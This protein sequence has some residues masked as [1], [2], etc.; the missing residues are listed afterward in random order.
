MSPPI[1][2]IDLGT[3]YSLVS[4][5]QAGV[6]LV[7]PNV[8]GE[9]LTPSAVS[10]REDG[11]LLVGA[12]AR[13]RATTHPERTALAFKRDMGTQRQLQL[14]ERTFSPVELSAL[15][16]E[17]LKRDAEVALG[18]AIT[19]AVVT[20]PAYFGDLQRQATRDAGALAGLVVERIV[21]EPTAAA[22]AYGLHERSRDQRVVV[23]DLGGGTF[24]VTVL[25]L[26]EGVM[27]V[28]ASA[29]DVRLGGEDFTQVLAERLAERF[30]RERGLRPAEDLRAWARLLEASEAAKQRLSQADQVAVLLPQLSCGKRAPIDFEEV[31]TRDEAEAC[32]A[33]L[34]ARLRAPVLRALRDAGIGAGQV[35]EVLLVGGATRMPVVQRLVTEL[36]G[37]LPLR[38]LPPDEA[39][40]MGA[41]VQAALKD[42]DRSVKD[43]VVTDVAP[44]TLGINTASHS[45][46]RVVTGLF[47]PI[48]ERGTVIPASRMARVQTVADYQSEIRV[49]VYQGEHSLC[50]DNQKLGE[51]RLSSLPPRPAGDESVD[52]RLTY[53][54]NGIVEVEMTVVSTGTVESFVIEQRPGQLSA[55]EL[56]KARAAMAGLKLHPR[57]ALPNTTALA[58]ADARFMELT[59]PER[60]QLGHAIAMMR[61]ALETQEV[62]EVL[63]WRERLNALISLSRR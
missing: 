26:V 17:S 14:G 29:G 24:D 21:N 41:A 13:A 23:L 40:A 44:F 60:E 42:G 38:K 7:L 47:T 11:T 61:L 57:D 3:T 9:G 18:C 62:V 36:F 45:G 52:V 31:L 2:G 25:E 8:L 51:Y 63:V 59:G 55:S 43:M 32:W 54:L 10:V 58:R 35:D 1:V 5:L 20:V 34:V 49:E 6:P 50:R 16:L 22:M 27:E 39:V 30:T 28:Q 19:E 37:R 15:V 48:L 12:A 4:V 33:P 53:D 56:Q 46:Q